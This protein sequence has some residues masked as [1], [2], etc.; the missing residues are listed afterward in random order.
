M[1]KLTN[2]PVL[3]EKIPSGLFDMDESILFLNEEFCL[4]PLKILLTSIAA[5]H[6][7]RGRWTVRKMTSTTETKS[8]HQ[9]PT[10]IRA[11]SRSEDFSWTSL[12]GKAPTS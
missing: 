10:F 2:M 12:T 11:R 6:S 5:I 4:F 1:A 9:A 8:L 3:L 7:F